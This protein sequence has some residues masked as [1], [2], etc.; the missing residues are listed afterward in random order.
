MMNSST[1]LPE[2]SATSV[3]MNV[4]RG[5]AA[6]SLGSVLNIVGQLLVIPV[7]MRTWGPVRWGE[8]IVLAGSV[9]L[10]ATSDLGLQ[11][12]VVNRLCAAYACGE[13][14]RMVV[15]L[16]SALKIHLPLIAVII[17]LMANILPWVSVGT[18]LGLRTVRGA[19]LLALLLLLACDPLLGVPMGVVAGVYRATGRLARGAMAGNARQAALVLATVVLVWAGGGLLAL[20]L[21]R[22]TLA[23]GVSAW[24]LI[25]LKRLYPWLR[26]WPTEGSLGNGL[27]MLAPGI[28]FLLVPVTSYLG[29]EFILMIVQRSAGGSV[30]S[31][32]ATH[33]TA[34]NF[35]RTV[36]NALAF[37]IWPELTSLYARGELERLRAAHGVYVKLNL[38]LV[39]CAT[40]AIIVFLPSIY[41]SWTGGLTLDWLTVDFMAARLVLWGGSSASMT[42]LL[43][44]NRQR[45]VSLALA[46]SGLIGGFAAALLVPRIGISGAA[47]ATL[48]G[49]ICAPAWLL[50]LLASWETEELPLRLVRK[51]YAPPVISFSAALLAVLLGWSWILSPAARYLVVTPIGGLLGLTV[52]WSMASAWE[53]DVV[54]RIGWRFLT[55]PAQ[56]WRALINSEHCLSGTKIRALLLGSLIDRK[57]KSE[58]SA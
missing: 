51:A 23:I 20:A 3:A 58:S 41:R 31:R 17:A 57:D 30:V 26:L 9:S 54:C 37:A 24:I 40:F 42:L 49:D 22:V 47:L 11:S 14:D 7:V 50:P 48:L 5:V 15:D 29:N 56:F 44:I 45:K 38:Y 55:A 34:I 52:A 16:Q 46:I 39:L 25:D 21:V 10:L 27:A 1:A 12:F 32:Y 43:S 53:R 33:A 28:F 2:N 18:L 8:W 4:G 36:A 19:K 35:A 13:R 6:L